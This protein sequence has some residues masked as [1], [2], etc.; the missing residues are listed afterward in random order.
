MR[1]Q[2]I[3]PNRSLSSDLLLGVHCSCCWDIN[4]CGDQRCEPFWVIENMRDNIYMFASLNADVR[5]GEG[6]LWKSKHN[7]KLRITVEHSHL[8]T[9][10]ACRSILFLET[11][12]SLPKARLLGK[13]MTIVLQK[14]RYR[15]WTLFYIPYLIKF[16]YH[17]LTSSTDQNPNN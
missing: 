5:H 4:Y 1:A 17:S 2:I 14:Y 6:S 7:Q 10:A 12:S 15:V 8:Y 3:W 16:V 11:A 9:C 13:T